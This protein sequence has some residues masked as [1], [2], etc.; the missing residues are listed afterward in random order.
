MLPFCHKLSCGRIP[1]L[2]S[3]AI[4]PAF[5]EEIAMRACIIGFIG[6]IAQAAISSLPA[7]E[8]QGLRVCLVS[9]SLEYD[10][11]TSMPILQTRLEKKGAVCSRA[12]IVG[13][14]ESRLPGLE[15][16]ETTDVMVLFT[17]RLKLTGAEL[18]RFKKYCQSGKPIVGLRTASHAVQT[19][20][21]LDKEVFGGDYASHFGQGVTTVK[22]VESA[23]KHPILE[24]V[25]PFTS[26]GSLYKNT[27]IAKDC[28]VLLTGSIPNITMPVAW[29]RSYKGGRIV[30]TSL[31]HPKDFENENFLRLVENAVFWAG[32]K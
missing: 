25:E 5:V 10:S 8:A 23:K 9:G 19:W 31:G 32:K 17:R 3:G 1:S 20:L 11:N 30:Y 15:H 27:K 14:D 4:I 28:E 24:G 16:L 6:V 26:E 18:D 13:H 21:D 12:F 22:I 29:T 7:Q 2:F